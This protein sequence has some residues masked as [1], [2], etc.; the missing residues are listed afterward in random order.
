MN[1]SKSPRTAWCTGL[2][3]VLGFAAQLPA[4]P[5]TYAIDSSQSVL[6]LSGSFQGFPFSAQTPAGL[7]VDYLGT[8]SG[9]LVGSTL[10]LAG[11]NAVIAFSNADAAVIVPAGIGVTNYGVQIAAIPGQIGAYR[12]V[13][14]DIPGG[15][16]ANGVAGG[17]TWA[18]SSGKLDYDGPATG[19]GSLT[20]IG[21]SAPNASLSP[22]SLSTVGLE[23]TLRIPLMLTMNDNAGLIQTLQGEIVAVRAVPEPSTI[24]LIAWGGLTLVVA[25]RRRKTVR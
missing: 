3:L 14:L 13:I 11:G 2:A 19:P 5:V 20:L 6:T 21:V 10:N 18:F 8:I 25:R 22:V 15:S 4:A 9:D 7:V 23:E 17:Q 12:D 24:A 1:R 16:A